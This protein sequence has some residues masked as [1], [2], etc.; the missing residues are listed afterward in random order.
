MPSTTQ[1]KK[2]KKPID[3]QAPQA[4]FGSSWKKPLTDLDL[5]SGERCQVKRPGV[6]G[7]I[8]AGVLHSLDSLTAIVQQDTIPKAEGKPSKAVEEVVNDPDK[9]RRMMEMVDK[10]V[11]HTV[12]Q[13]EVLPSTRPVLD[14]NNQPK[15]DRDGEPI[16]EDIPDEERDPE[17]VY[18]DYIDSVDKMF[19]MNF[20]VGGSAD[21]AEFRAQTEALVGGVPAGE[22]DADTAE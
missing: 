12:T 14:D 9:F 3:R 17:A 2:P 19:I 21:L 4:N 13:P 22:A 5:P 18:V 7:L 6:Q 16:L 15:T 8:K 20:A 11:V 10:I 1:G